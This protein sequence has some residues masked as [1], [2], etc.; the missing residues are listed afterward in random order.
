MRGALT[1]LLAASLVAPFALADHPQSMDGSAAGTYMTF[2]H[3]GGNEWWVEVRLAGP[4]ADQNLNVFARDDGGD[5]KALTERDWGNW[6][7][8]FRIEPGNRVQFRAIWQGNMADVGQWTSCW[9]THP[10]GVEQ[11]STAP[12]PPPSGFDATF[13]GV[14]GNAWWVETKVAATG[15]TVSGVDARVDGGAW[16]ALDKKS[17]GAWAKS[18]NAPSGSTVQFRARATSGAEDLSGCY[19]WTAATPVTCP[20]APST[21]W[22]REGSFV[23]YEGTSGF[24]VPGYGYGYEFR[25]DLRFTGGR[26]EGRCTGHYT[27]YG[28]D[29]ITQEHDFD[30][31]RDIP[32]LRVPVAPTT[33]SAFESKGLEGMCSRD[34]ATVIARADGGTEAVMVSGSVVTVETTLAEEDPETSP[35]QSLESTSDAAT[36]LVLRWGHHRSRSGDSGHVTGTDAPIGPRLSHAQQKE[37]VGAWPK[38]GSFVEYHWCREDAT[39]A[40]C[41][42]SSNL[43]LEY[44]SGKWSG[45][46]RSWT[47]DGDET[48]VSV[49][50]SPLKGPLTASKGATP[51]VDR[52]GGCA[53]TS[54]QLEIKGTFP[55]PIWK[56]CPDGGTHSIEVWWGDETSWSSR[57]KDAVWDVETGLVVRWEYGNEH[58]GLG[59]TD[60]EFV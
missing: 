34:N 50:F 8:S 49:A 47:Y 41:E 46:C 48:T 32:P 26:W 54:T 13:T 37:M 53:K 58:G 6:A 33:G 40:Y 5:W 15:G 27:E 45:S 21:Q 10:A 17:W 18:I 44:R 59:A 20:G 3:R 57:D 51:Y 52:L 31:E 4:A 38:E 42:R 36:G 11:C 23:T 22:P 29:G 9:F 2:D 25:L 39:G 55:E 1:L 24:G 35:Y 28:D 7:G 19:R 14:K 30:I 16:K 12:A 56:C 60:V 43:R